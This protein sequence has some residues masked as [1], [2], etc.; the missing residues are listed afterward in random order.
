[1]N[2]IKKYLQSN[3][4]VHRVIKDVFHSKPVLIDHLAHRTFNITNIYKDYSKYKY[5]LQDE[6]YQFHEHNA[7]AEWWKCGGDNFN[8]SYTN[9]LYKYNNKIR[10]TPR[11]FLSKY[12]GVKRDKNFYG[13]DID[14]NLVQWHID[15]PS[16]QM[17][18]HLYEQLTCHNQYLAWTLLHR[19]SVNHI[20][21]AVDNIE[22]IAE[23]VEKIYSLNNPDAPIQVSKD[24]DL[25]QFSTT[26]MMKP[27]EF[28]EG[29]REVPYN[30]LEFVER[31]NN[32]EGFSTKNAN[33]ILNSTTTRIVSSYD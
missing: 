11:I 12:I 2:Y 29:T 1:M 30:F 23:K 33:I 5:Q 22:T 21:I 8:N 32:R 3:N 27:Y 18:Y 26:S 9:E 15:N 28:I 31:K 13:T 14:L 19:E 10:G 7:T 4:Q 24:G 16:A 17:S 6:M 25:L 20:G